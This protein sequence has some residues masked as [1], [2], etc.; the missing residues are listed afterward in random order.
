MIRTLRSSC[1]MGTTLRSIPKGCG[2]KSPKRP[3][4]KSHQNSAKY[5]QKKD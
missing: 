4:I 5:H 3:G 2:T 1:Y